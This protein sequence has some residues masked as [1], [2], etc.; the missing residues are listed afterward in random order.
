MSSRNIR[1]GRPPFAFYRV[2]DKQL[3]KYITLIIFFSEV[4]LLYVYVVYICMLQS[5]SLAC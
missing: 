4:I 5:Y 2:S 3:C 1:G